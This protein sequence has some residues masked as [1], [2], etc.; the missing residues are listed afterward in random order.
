MSKNEEIREAMHELLD[1]V[2][3]CNGFESR[4]QEKTGNKPTVFLRYFGHTNE[5]EI[6]ISPAGWFPEEC[7]ETIL[8]MYLDHWVD[9]VEIE[10]A[11]ARLN[12]FGKESK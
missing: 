11:I 10:N 2:L 6:N 7:P 3:E 12:E 5:V 1:A 8:D 9:A 4:K